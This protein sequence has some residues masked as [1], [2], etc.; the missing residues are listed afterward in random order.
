MDPA[1]VVAVVRVV[2]V[3]GLV[4]ELAVVGLVAVVGSTV[5]SVVVSIVELQPTW[6]AP[7]H[8][9]SSYNKTFSNFY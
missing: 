2:L 8:L 5:E 1:E 6:K 7:G 4:V 9:P 3:V